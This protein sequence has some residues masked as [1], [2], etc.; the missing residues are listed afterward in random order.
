[1]EIWKPIP[2]LIGYEASNQGRIRSISREVK[3]GGGTRIIPTTILSPVVVK[4][5]DYLQV[6]IFGK[7]VSAH[8]VIALTWCDG[9]FDGAWV[10][11]VNGV[12][13]D[14]R[15]ENLEWVTASENSK[16]SYAS[17]RV[18]PTKGAFSAEHPTS[19]AVVS[20]DL[21][22]GAVMYWGSAMDA[23]REGFHSSCISR[24]CNGLSK[25]HKGFSWE[26]G[27]RHGVSWSE[28]N[29]YEVPA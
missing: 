24:C 18:S 16:R 19:K 26:Y 11:H 25:S 6:K 8:R 27:D 21:R 7:K 3:C 5:T 14:N 10:D 29:P 1:M 12:R 4:N 20:T 28:P 17:G 15:P 23:V 13:G 9:F 22:T 2:N